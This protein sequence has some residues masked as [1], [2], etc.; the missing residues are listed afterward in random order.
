MMQGVRTTVTLD[1][2]LAAELQRL[3][4]ERGSGFRSVINDV[5]RRGLAGAEPA[6]TPY[7]VPSRRLGLRADVDV[8]KALQ[9]ASG[10]EDEDIVRKMS[11]RK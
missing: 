6:A 8:V 11:L 9:L 2:D 7:R 4:R 10:L 3:A 1:D 5:L